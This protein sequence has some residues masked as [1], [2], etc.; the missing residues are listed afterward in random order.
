MPAFNPRGPR[1]RTLNEEQ[2]S[3][4]EQ[5]ENV[6][7]EVDT[8]Q[9]SGTDTAG[10][11]HFEDILTLPVDKD[12]DCL[13][14]I[15]TKF[16]T[17]RLQLATLAISLAL[18]AFVITYVQVTYA[19]ERSSQQGL[20]LSSLLKTNASTILTIL[21]ASQGLL[22]MLTTLALDGAFVLL[23]CNSMVLQQGIPYLTLLSL[24]PSTNAWGLLVN[25]SSVTVYDMAMSY[26]VTAGVGRFNGSLVQPFRTFLHSLQ[27]DYPYETIPY[28][29]LASAYTLVVNPLIATVA[30]PRRCAAE[31]CISYLLSGGLT[32]VTP[33]VPR[34][35]VEYSLVR[36]KHAP[37]IQADFSGPLIN[38]VSFSD[39]DCDVFGQESILIGIR[40]CL[41]VI[42]A[43]PGVLT[44]G[45]FVCPDG[46]ANGACSASTPAPNMTIQVSFHSLQASF[47]SSRKNYTI[48]SIVDTTEA[49]PI[50]DLDLPAYRDALRW[51]L[52]YTDA[53]LP[54]P[55]SIAQSFWSSQGLLEDPSAWGI[56]AQNFQSILV[57]PFWLF[58]ANNWGNTQIQLNATISTMP[59]EF[60]TEASLVEPYTKLR[61]DKGMFALFLTLQIVA[62]LFVAGVV[63]WV[64]LGK[65]PARKA[66]SFPLF[67]ILFRA[68]LLSPEVWRCPANISDSKIISGLKETK[69]KAT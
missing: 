3:V 21:R 57:F 59:P 69:V 61:V 25:T 51:L 17:L 23:H 5:V 1:R 66:S 44:A 18:L 35:H 2:V 60:Y 38:G 7:G 36:V 39:S 63:V 40:L 42:P 30:E 15:L 4:D 47:V 55:T 10:S 58:N 16:Q 31:P 22:S 53:N 49:T 48:V 12:E 41:R 28:N 6:S 54:P 19:A 32:S 20:Q 26:P 67:D 13:N 46:I 65:R 27:P 62:L 56:L 11:K 14:K 64:W 34:D 37:T 24:S 9:S 45:M 68:E 29:Y 43:R 52:N 8:M 50:L 33:L